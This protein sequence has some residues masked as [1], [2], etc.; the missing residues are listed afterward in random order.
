MNLSNEKIETLI[1]KINENNN[2]CLFVHENP[3]C[4]TLGSA[5][6]FKLFIENNF[7]NKDVR[8]AG[9]SNLDP[10]FL[11]PFFNVKYELVDKEFAQDSIGIIF[12]VAVQRRILTQL[13]V[14]CN[15]TFVF[16]HH[17]NIEK[18]KI[19]NVE[20]IDHKASSTCEIIASFFKK[21]NHKYKINEKICE[22]LY[23]G[24]LTDTNRF[25]YPITSKK[26]FEIMVW[27]LNYKFNKE[28]VHNQLYLKSISDIELDNKLFNLINFNLEK[29]YATLFIDS[30]YN[31]KFNQNSFHGKINLMANI[32]NIEIWTLVY[33]DSYLKKWKGSIRSRN[34]DVS[35]IASKFNGGGHKLA[36]GFLLTNFK[37]TKELENE[38]IKF[39]ENEQK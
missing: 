16:D 21:I 26:T 32:K 31:K 5:Y 1:K 7:K 8:I 28:M 15:W 6:A 36:S 2:I 20:F 30:K 17:P 3:D 4:D 12:D 14:F 18:N 33:Y 29:K 38:I 24:L 13:N 25:L 34:Y 37:Q 11:L 22:S 23:F 27:M 19:A 39:L 10:K 35:K 9:L